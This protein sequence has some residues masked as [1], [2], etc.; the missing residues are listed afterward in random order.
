MKQKAIRL[1]ALAM[2]IV[3]T[4]A[5][6]IPHSR[7]AETD[8]YRDE[9]RGVWVATV[10]NIDFT[11]AGGT[12]AEMKAELSSILD[13]AEAAGLNAVFFQVRPTGDAFYHSEIFPYSKYF[14]GEEGK[15][16]DNNF[17]ALQYMIDEG[18]KRGIEIHAWVNPY[19]VATGTPQNPATIEGLSDQ[20]PV[21][22]NPEMAVSYNG[23]LYLDPGN[24][25]AMALIV[26]GV[27]EIVQNYDVAGVQFDDYFYPGADFDDSA[28][29]AAYGAGRSLEDFRRQNTY[30]LIKAAGEAVHEIDPDVAFGVSPSG[31]WRNSSSDPEGSDTSGNE[32]YSALYADTKKWVEDRL[33]DYIAPQL[34]WYIGQPGSDFEVLSKWW[35][36]LCA[37]SDVAL[38]TGH[39][40]YKVGTNA[41]WSRDGE[42]LN[43]VALARQNGASGQIFY[44]F[45]QLK[46]N[47]LG[48]SEG[49]A[50]YYGLSE[51]KPS[52]PDGEVQPLIIGLPSSSSYSCS[53]RNIYLLGTA[54]PRYPVTLNGEVLERTPSGHFSAFMPLSSGKNY[55]TFEH[56]GVS[57]TITVTRTGRSL[58]P[59]LAP[60]LGEAAPLSSFSAEGVATTTARIKVDETVVRGGP[61]SGAAKLA[62]M[63]KGVEDQVV[64]RR[65]GYAKLRSGQ[66][67]PESALEFSNKV[68]PAN[69]IRQAT[70]KNTGEFSELRLRA[71]YFAPYNV[72]IDASKMT[73]TIYNTTGSELY[74][75]V[76]SPLVERVEFSQRGED[77]VYTLYWREEGQFLGF[78]VEMVGN[79]VCFQLKNPK[80]LAA[81]DRPLAGKVI[82]VDAGHGGDDPGALGPYGALKGYE[83]ELNLRL[84]DKL[85]EELEARG[86]TVRMT[87][88]EDV[89]LSLDD[90]AEMIKQES[91]D[92]SISVHQNSL[93]LD[94][95]GSKVEG[96]LVMYREEFSATFAQTIA[97]AM[98]EALPERRNRGIT[99]QGLAVCYIMECPSILVEA[100][101][102]NNPNEYER[103]SGDT[104]MSRQ[105]AAIADGVVDFFATH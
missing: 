20:N 94:T 62:P 79:T 54:D 22:K 75:A 39:A 87:R 41:E 2:V 6:A 77:A 40:A 49:L 36:E 74:G 85:K 98:G 7:A 44:G 71:D 38:Y 23:G 5:L 37:E 88:T 18:K 34:Y 101:F 28:S 29:F 89:Y 11:E 32:A 53:Y 25:E 16:P 12:E 68:L 13:T 55:F 90:R 100:G 82:Y 3:L 26:D 47:T 58:A 81:G 17:D 42:L 57:K 9:L 21:K 104:E 69:E 97:D 10:Y 66:Y 35:G 64:E 83:S 46:A 78:E 72:E 65:N 92:L 91:P 52:E 31:I 1:L 99:K 59:Q 95:D 103:L 48:I 56:N 45:A 67:V 73:L 76:D 51:D 102:I 24:K 93:G 43:Q 27:R 8:T 70:V 96:F 60:P 105:A 86:A 33:V 50:W 14:T 30:D 63:V 19:R 84:A 80:G 61:S 4:V 15:A